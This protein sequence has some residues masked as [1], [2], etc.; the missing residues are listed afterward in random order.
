ML[1]YTYEVVVLNNGDSRKISEVINE[2]AYG[3]RIVSM[4]FSAGGFY[5]FLLEDSYDTRDL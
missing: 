1:Q 3:R 5:H 2:I 4:N